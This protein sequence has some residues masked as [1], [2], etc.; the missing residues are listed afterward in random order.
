MQLGASY[1]WFLR[2]LQPYGGWDI[3]GNHRKDIS[4]DWLEKTQTSG[5]WNNWHSLGMSVYL[6]SN[7]LFTLDTLGMVQ[8]S[9]VSTCMVGNTFKLT[10]FGR[11]FELEK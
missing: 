3:S 2:W 8:G 9:M 4:G 11:H 7:G 6:S 5:G 1:T 10:F